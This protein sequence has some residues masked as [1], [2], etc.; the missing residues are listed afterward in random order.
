MGGLIWAENHTVLQYGCEYDIN[1]MYPYLMTQCA[2]ITRQPV[3]DT[4]Q[5]L[6]DIK[7]KTYCIVR[8]KISNY[9]K[10][11]FKSNKHNFSQELISNLH[12]K[13]DT[14]LSF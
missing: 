9:D 7:H 13:K 11:I 12:K 10:L 5:T 8:C 6:D 3:F 14:R 4:I 2:Y 1:S